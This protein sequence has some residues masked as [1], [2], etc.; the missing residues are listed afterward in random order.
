MKDADIEVDQVP[1]LLDL[2]AA[3]FAARQRM[4]D[5]VSLTRP[6]L[7]FLVAIT[8]L[9]G[10]CLGANGPIDLLTLV[11]TLA[12]TTLITGGAFGLNQVIER[13]TDRLMW[14]T[15]GRPLPGRRMSPACAVVVSAIFSAGG[16]LLLAWGASLL[17]AGL[18][19]ATFISYNVIYTPLKRRSPM[20]ML[21]GAVPGALPP[22]IGW[23]AAR[24][25]LSIE[26]WTLFAIVFVWQIPHVLALASLHGDDYARGG[27]PMLPAQG[28]HSRS[29]GRLALLFA[30][31][32]PPV[33]LVPVV[34][35]LAGPWYGAGASALGI[36][37]VC[38][39]SGF[40]RDR[41]TAHARRLFL[42]ST[43]Y[44]PLLWG[45]LIADHVMF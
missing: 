5:L 19:L 6:R 42:G 24:E 32:L 7:S 27:F 28:P 34:V 2:S 26:A 12:G 31:A 1:L 21:V 3:V 18:A 4:A 40:A 29:A 16:L 8:A 44:L 39:S 17:A 36:G 15:R 45:L 25:S 13:D 38:L 10:F 23:S 41:T 11:K 43:V 14:R 33:S 20:A 22:M 9:A 30:A 35:H 37:L